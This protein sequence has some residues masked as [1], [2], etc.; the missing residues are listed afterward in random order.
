MSEEKIKFVNDFTFLG[1]TIDK[2]LTWKNQLDKISKKLSKTIGIMNRLKRFLPQ[3]IL[4]TLY[5]SLCL[6]H[7]TYGSLAWGA[8]NINNLI[9]IQKKAIRVICNT[10]Y[11]AHTEPL[12]KNREILKLTDLIKLN[13]LRFCYK[14]ETGTLPK[15]FLTSY[16]TKNEEVHSNNASQLHL[17]R[18]PRVKNKLAKK[19]TKFRICNTYNNCPESI[20]SK[21]Y[22]HSLKGFINYIK[23]YC[24]HNYRNE[25]S[26]VGCYICNR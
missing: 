17:Y 7:L 16:V 10:K 4:I 13:E 26:I 3:K 11:N 5:N 12:F 18:I 9:K 25:C 14:F 21:I 1:V 22:T 6:P 23:Y 19:N 2:N 20:R 8:S 15:Y 24:L